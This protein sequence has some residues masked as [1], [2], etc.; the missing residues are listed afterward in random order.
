MKNWEIISAMV[1]ENWKTS[2]PLCN[3]LLIL[4][5]EFLLLIIP[6]GIVFEKICP[7]MMPEIIAI[8]IEV[9]IVNI[10]T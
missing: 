1:N 8:T 7:G 3:S 10:H 2:N 5:N 4:I 9:H 6:A